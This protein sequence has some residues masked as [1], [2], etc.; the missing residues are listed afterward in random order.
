MNTPPCLVPI[1]SRPNLSSC[2]GPLE[3]LWLDEM[4]RKNHATDNCAKNSI[5]IIIIIIIK[6]I[7]IIIIINNDDDDDDDD[8]DV[9]R[10]KN[11]AL[12]Y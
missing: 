6:I 4:Q 8:V 3:K 1:T 11:Y 9:T 2:Y 7:I 5:I 10:K 12:T